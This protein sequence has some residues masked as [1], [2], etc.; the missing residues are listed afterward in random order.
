MSVSKPERDDYERGI[1]DEKLGWFDR[2][3]N[4]IFINHP[5]SREYD[6]GRDGKQLDDHEEDE[7]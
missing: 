3:V 7:E 6:L 2:A 1:A 4:D 5:E